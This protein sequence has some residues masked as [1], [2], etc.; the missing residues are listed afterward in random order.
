MG[1]FRRT[2]ELFWWQENWQG[3]RIGFRVGYRQALDDIQKT[4]LHPV[5]DEAIEESIKRAERRIIES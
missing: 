5:S 2:R 4:G 3:F 1:W